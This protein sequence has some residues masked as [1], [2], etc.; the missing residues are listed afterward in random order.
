MVNSHLE[1]RLGAILQSLNST[2]AATSQSASAVKGTAR[3][4]F[5]QRYL[6]QV[7]PQG[8]RIRTNGEITDSNNNI[9]GELDI[10]IE[11][12][13]F[14]NIPLVQTESSRLYFAEGV[15]AVIE[16]KS[17][18]AGQ[19][20]EVMQTGSKLRTIK[21]SFAGGLFSSSTGGSIF[22]VPFSINPELS[23]GKVNNPK[24]EN[25]DH[26]PYFVV[27]YTGWQTNE[28]IDQKLSQSPYISGILQLDR[29]YYC[30]NSMFKG[31]TARGPLC[32][33]GF[34]DSIYEAFNYIKIANGNIL[35]YGQQ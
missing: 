25:I 5:I 27:G 21:R 4:E 35:K 19:W 8:L 14:P 12:G 6:E 28:T 15:A 32:L 22:Q 17:N 30:S 11:N 7:L 13:M 23:L 9:T 3:S 31:I 10:I 26:V 33:L 18:L 1:T 2:Y 24:Q 16:I 20:E 29:G 34:I